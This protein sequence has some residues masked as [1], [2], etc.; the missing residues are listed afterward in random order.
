MRESIFQNEWIASWRHFY[1]SCHIYKIPDA[2]KSSES[3]FLAKKPYDIDAL[4]DG[5][6]YKMELKLQTKVG[7][8]SFDSVTEWQIKNLKEAKDNGAVA[9]IAVNYRT[10][11]VSGQAKKKFG[12]D[13]TLNVVYVLDVDFFNS[14]DRNIYRKSIPFEDLHFNSEVLQVGRVDG[15]WDIRKIV[16]GKNFK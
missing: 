12:L 9:V 3:R 10:Q 4:F 16:K 1:P 6:A 5:R 14:L 8:F 13:G 7:A 11:K 2:I 15:F